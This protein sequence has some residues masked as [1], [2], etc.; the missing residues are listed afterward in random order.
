MH[1][2]KKGWGPLQKH[3]DRCGCRESRLGSDQRV[4]VP[5]LQVR[6]E[7]HSS[8]LVH[9]LD[10]S[11]Q[12]VPFSQSNPIQHGSPA[13]QEP[14]ARERQST[15][16]EPVVPG[17]QIPLQHSLSAVQEPVLVGLKFGVQHLPLAQIVPLQH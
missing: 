10:R 15:Q 14:P 3:R 7:Q 6:P 17:S 16:K 1:K 4:Q 12:Q 2:G 8:S 11:P 9:S 13:A 5:S